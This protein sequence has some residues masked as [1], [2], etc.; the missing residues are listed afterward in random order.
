MELSKETIS[1]AENIET[2]EN[3]ADVRYSLNDGIDTVLHTLKPREA[4]ILSY[5][6][7]L[8]DGAAHTLDEVGT[9]FNVSRERTRQILATS[10][11]RLR[12]PTNSRQLQTVIGEQY[13]TL[14]DGEWALLSDTFGL[15]ISGGL[16]DLLGFV[17]SCS[18]SVERLRRAEYV[19]SVSAELADTIKH[20]VYNRVIEE[21]SRNLERAGFNSKAILKSE[22]VAKGDLS[23]ISVE[24]AGFSM[25]SYNC[26]KRVSINNLSQ[27]VE[28]VKKNHKGSIENTLA[29]SDGIRNLGKKSAIEILKWAGVYIDLVALEA[30][31]A[32]EANSD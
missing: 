22:S 2:T 21:V 13:G 17:S 24:D 25:R 18:E 31:I 8:L 26:L 20:E 3:N 19:S 11:R 28:Y 10:Q 15:H 16:A 6:H 9:K 7:G 23:E 14:T 5:R 32:F 29:A 12:C 4:A 27:F 30:E 1:G